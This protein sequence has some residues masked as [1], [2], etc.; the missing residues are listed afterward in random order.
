LEVENGEGR[1]LQALGDFVEIALAVD[2]EIDTFGQV[3]AG[4]CQFDDVSTNIGSSA[5]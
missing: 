2:G 3:L 1:C 5:R 4:Y